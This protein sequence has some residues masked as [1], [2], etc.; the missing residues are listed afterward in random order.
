M[1]FAE[2]PDGGTVGGPGVTLRYW[3]AAKQAAGAAEE[4][5]GSVG[6]LAELLDRARAAHPDGGQLARVLARCSFLVDG[7][8]VGRRPHGQVTLVAGSV[9][10]ALPPFA[11]G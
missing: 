5:F 6:T 11:G 2:H 3:A 1:A 4:R 7:E 8:P 10:E 9:V